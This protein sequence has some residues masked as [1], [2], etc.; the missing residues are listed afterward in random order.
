MAI[1]MTPLANE[2][3]I[4]QALSSESPKLR[5]TTLGKKKHGYKVPPRPSRPPIL[6]ERDIQ[7]LTNILKRDRKVNFGELRED[8]V[9]STTKNVCKKTLSFYSRVGVKK[10]FASE[11]IG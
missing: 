6:T 2:S 5:V 4:Q 11:K 1:S 7:H 10:P 9:N 8:F 3:N